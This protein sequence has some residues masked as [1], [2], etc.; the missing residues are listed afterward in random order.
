MDLKDIIAVIPSYEPDENLLKVIKELSLIPFGGILIIDDGSGITYNW[1]FEQCK[2]Y[3]NCLNIKCIFLSH[4]VNCG[5]G[6]ALK[7]CFKYILKNIPNC[8]GIVTADGDGQHKTDDIK[9]I[10]YELCKNPDKLIL[11]S[12]NCLNQQ[13]PLRSRIGNVITRNVFS[14]L[15]GCNIKDTQSGLRGF[16]F[17]NMKKFI[18]INGER[19]DYEMYMLMECRNL[20]LKI[21]EVNIQTVYLEGNRTSHFNPLIDSLRIYII[22]LKFISSSFLAAFLDFIIFFIMIKLK[23][24]LL[25][26]MIAARTVSSLSNFL[27]N[28]NI[29]FNS[30]TDSFKSGIKYYSLVILIGVLSYLLIGILTFIKGMDVLMAKILA[31]SFLFFL[32][33]YLQRIFVFK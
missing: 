14:F 13:V 28:K 23:Y 31:E 15:S 21:L 10:A 30:G 32:S 22:F 16:S 24:S 8:K 17:E 26:A 33:Y 2:N 6:A 9:K 11:G 18:K 12:R 1:I 27:I 7:T 4:S 3:I 19:F 29:V 20:K 5:K 25:I